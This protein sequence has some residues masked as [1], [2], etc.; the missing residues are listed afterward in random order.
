MHPPR[1]RLVVPILL[2]LVGVV[3]SIIYVNSAMVRG[4]NDELR[5]A[6]CFW[7]GP[8]GP[9][10]FQAGGPSLDTCKAF[11]NWWRTAQVGYIGELAIVL[12]VILA[13]IDVKQGA[14]R[15]WQ[16]DGPP[17]PVRCGPAQFSAKILPR[18]PPR[19]QIASAH[20]LNG[21]QSPDSEVLD[22]ARQAEKTVI[23]AAIP[24]D[25]VAFGGP[26]WHEPTG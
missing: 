16:P 2:A 17:R 19:K 20:W 21:I 3:V 12:A 25:E 15:G 4:P 10:L 5:A 1:F 7:F 13:C 9:P 22:Q 11:A 26:K 8:D 14:G 6:V 18:R 23:P 24:P